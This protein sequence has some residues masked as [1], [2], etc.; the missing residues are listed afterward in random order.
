MSDEKQQP[1]NNIVYTIITVLASMGLIGGGGGYLVNSNIDSL[2]SKLSEEIAVIKNDMEH[3]IKAQESI[4][5]QFL[6]DFKAHVNDPNLHLQGMQKVKKEVKE[7]LSV[8][9]RK[10]WEII[11]EL[12]DRITKIEAWKESQGGN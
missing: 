9:M 12:R 6:E 10:Q 1:K 8:P 7:E 4:S 2:G 11:S 3:V 5:E